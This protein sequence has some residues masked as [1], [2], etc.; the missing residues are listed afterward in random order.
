VSTND[1]AEG[2]GH[3][4]A[5]ELMTAYYEALG[6]PRLDE[7]DALFAPDADWRFP[8]AVLRGPQQVKRAMQRSLDTG[9]RMHHTIELMLEQGDTAICELEATNVV[10]GRAYT[11]RGAVVCTAS[12]GRITR[13]AAYPDATQMMA[14][15]AAIE[16]APRS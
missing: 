13:M 12:E 4:T 3:R 16:A 5:A 8:G 2:R 10:G 15:L 1:A 7:L 6:V 9:L 14:F 11:V